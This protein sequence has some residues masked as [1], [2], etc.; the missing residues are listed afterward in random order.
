VPDGAAPEGTSKGKPKTIEYLYKFEGDAL[1]LAVGTGDDPPRPTEFKPR[2]GG[3]MTFTFTAGQPPPPEPPEPLA[4]GVQV[5]TLKKTDVPAPPV[6][7]WQVV[8]TKLTTKK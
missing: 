1:V 5:I 8:G 6:T 7:P 3:T 4:P 2:A